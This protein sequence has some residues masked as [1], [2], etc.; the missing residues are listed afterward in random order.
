MTKQ[1]AKKLTG[2]TLADFMTNTNLSQPSEM[3]LTIDKKETDHHLLI[4]GAQSKRVSRA[5]MTWGTKTNAL[6][7]ALEPIK[8]EIDKA[9]KRLEE[10][11]KISNA[12]ALE[13]VVGWSFGDYKISKVAELLDENVGLADAVI[14]HAFAKESTLVKK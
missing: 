4:V 9:V 10:E 2:L 6:N 7:K 13:L 12:F 5:R 8:D 1:K 3:A 14:S 11:S